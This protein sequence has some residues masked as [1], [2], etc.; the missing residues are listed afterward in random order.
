MEVLGYGIE[1]C[2]ACGPVTELMKGESGHPSGSLLDLHSGSFRSS[3]EAPRCFD[4]MS[5]S[6]LNASWVELS[7]RKRCPSRTG[8]AS[9]QRAHRERLLAGR[10]PRRTVSF[11]RKPGRHPS[12]SRS[13]NEVMR[14][15]E[16]ESSE[17]ER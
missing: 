1:V 2:C 17:E 15:L 16:S 13:D 4:T 5:V 10:K 12:P 6:I 7:S 14:D 9:W 8:K 11:S 3:T